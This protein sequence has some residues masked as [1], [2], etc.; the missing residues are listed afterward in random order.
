MC[1][2][3]IVL[4]I[5]TKFVNK[6]EIVSGT[7]SKDSMTPHLSSLCMFTR[8]FKVLVLMY[9]LIFYLQKI[10]VVIYQLLLLVS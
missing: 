1:L 3:A 9:L 6:E 4:S 5:G 2:T 10:I 8:I 7:H